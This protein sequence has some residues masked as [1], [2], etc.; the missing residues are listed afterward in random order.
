MLFVAS[1]VLAA[2]NS[3]IVQMQVG[4]DT[5]PP[6]TPADL[7][8]AAVTSTQIDLSWTASTDDL[9]VSGYQVFRDAVAI[10]TTSQTTYS[11][12]GLTSGTSYSY[13][14]QAFDWAGNYSSSSDAVS[15]TTLSEGSDSITPEQ[16]VV[17]GF[18]IV[19]TETT[20][21]VRFNTSLYTRATIRWGRTVNYELG[22]IAS[23]V[24]KLDHVTTI[25]DLEPGT[26]YEL[27]IILE[28]RFVGDPVI[29]RVQFTTVSLPDLI[30]PPNVKNAKAI[31]QSDGIAVTWDNPEVED[32]SNV[33]VMSSDVWYPA[34]PQDGWFVYDDDS[35]FV[36]DT[37]A[38]ESNSRFYTIFSYDKS[39]NRSSGAVVSVPLGTP[40]VEDNVT[41]PFL[42]VSKVDVSDY[43]F[44]DLR[45]LKIIQTGYVQDGDSNIATVSVDE[46]IRFSIPYEE[47]PEHLKTV[48][49]TISDPRD[50]SRTFSFLLSINAQKTA[51]EATIGSLDWAGAYDVLVTIYDYQSKA[52]IERVGEFVAVKDSQTDSIYYVAQVKVNWPLIFVAFV[53][54]SLLLLIFKFASDKNDQQAAV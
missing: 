45:D 2:S 47:L 48:V 41:E 32:F 7:I 27:E 10:A 6:T 31:W 38:I 53:I 3:F 16:T 20:A 40:V 1:P 14:V 49:V 12:T 30:A 9:L 37:R 4:A 44:F 22:Y 17:S 5:S 39:G 26:I 29:E 36:R 35:E 23:D 42:P 21:E 33:R 52:V 25:T 24:F 28:R 46:E 50:K 8:A 13:Y 19:P 11:D 54:F 34:D 18:E 43:E 51:Y 15:Q